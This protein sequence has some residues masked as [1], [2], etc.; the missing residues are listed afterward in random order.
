MIEMKLTQGGYNFVK[1]KLIFEADILSIDN[2]TGGVCIDLRSG[3]E[4]AYT[5]ID[6]LNLD[7]HKNTV[8]DAEDKI[9]DIEEGVSH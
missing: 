5:L 3:L 9:V 1:N 6:C 7:Y 8:A 4:V 2:T